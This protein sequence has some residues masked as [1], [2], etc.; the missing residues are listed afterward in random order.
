MTFLQFCE[1]IG[2]GVLSCVPSAK[3]QAPRQP[4][5]PATVGFGG[6]KAAVTREDD[7]WL[8]VFSRTD[9]VAKQTTL[10][11]KTMTEATANN[12]AQSIVAFLT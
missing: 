4:K 2:D 11:G 5:G 12:I 6:A 8:V 7:R 10:T 1:E 9:G 3:Y